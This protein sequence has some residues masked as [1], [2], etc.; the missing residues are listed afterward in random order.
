MDED[1]V[2]PFTSVT[3]TEYVPAARLLSDEEVPPPG[4]HE[5]EYPPAPPETETEALP[6]LSPLHEISECEASS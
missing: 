1:V 2:H 5:Y 3:L 6:L 4:V